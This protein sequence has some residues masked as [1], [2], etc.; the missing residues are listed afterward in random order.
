[1]SLIYISLCLLIAK[2]CALYPPGREGR[3]GLRVTNSSTQRGLIPIYS[4]ALNGRRLYMQRGKFKAHRYL[5]SLYSTY[6]HWGRLQ[7]FYIKLY[8]AKTQTLI[9]EM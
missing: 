1:M 7:S 5:V 4:L 2:H 8:Y 6:D 9:L 3:R